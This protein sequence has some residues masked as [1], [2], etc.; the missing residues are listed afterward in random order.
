MENSQQIQWKEKLVRLDD[1]RPYERNPRQITDCQYS[2]LKESL[3]EDGYHSR[4]KATIDGRVMGGHQ[5]LKVLKE[6]GYETLIVLMPDRVLS[7]DE[8][9]RIMLR[10]NH[11]NGGWDMDALANEF[12]LEE[13]RDIGLHEIMNIAP[14]DEDDESHEP[15]KHE[16]KC[17]ECGGIF[18]TKG[19]GA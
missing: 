8:F 1:L 18:A 15:G 19:N 12:D 16:V 6:L 11:N 4:I 7:D 14:F 17:P 9:K 5:R 13:L 3:K 2:K 10:D